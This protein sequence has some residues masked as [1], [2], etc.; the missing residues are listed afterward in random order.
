MSKANNKNQK[1]PR[2]HVGKAKR[3]NMR[4]TGVP[5]GDREKCGVEERNNS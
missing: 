3:S 4:V 5:E 1:Q 2:G